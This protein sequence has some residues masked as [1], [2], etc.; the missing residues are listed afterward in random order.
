MQVFIVGSP[1]Y[2][3]K[4]LDKLRLNKQIIECS[5]ILSALNGKTKAWLNHPCTKQYEK[6]QLWLYYYRMSLMNYKLG[7]I[8]LAKLYSKNAD[9]I[10]PKFHIQE[11][12]NQMKRRLYT[13]NPIHYNLWENL[14][15]SY[16]NW[17]WSYRENKWLKY[18][19]LKS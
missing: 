15:E 9:C 13:K 1:I 2:T 6:H 18:K 7:N 11:Y 12:Y 3:A 10:R 16:E 5:Q 19:Q 17:Y 8:L 14:G 4:H